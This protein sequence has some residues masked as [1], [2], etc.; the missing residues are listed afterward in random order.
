MANSGSSDCLR[1]RPGGEI[2]DIVRLPPVYRLACALGGTD[3]RTLMMCG[4][5]L[6]QDNALAPSTSHLFTAEVVVGA[7][8]AVR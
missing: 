1:L 4:F 2:V 5:D 7:A 6:A 3:G 8:L